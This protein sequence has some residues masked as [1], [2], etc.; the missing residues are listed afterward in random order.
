M[1]KESAPRSVLLMMKIQRNVRRS[2]RFRVNECCSYVAIAMPL[3][4]ESVRPC[5]HGDGQSE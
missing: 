1:V 3:T 4:A 2:P 5:L